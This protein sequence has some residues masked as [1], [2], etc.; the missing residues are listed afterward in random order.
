MANDKNSNIFDSPGLNE[1]VRQRVEDSGAPHALS[2][3]M[4]TF[5]LEDSNNLRIEQSD[6]ETLIRGKTN[7]SIR[8]GRDRPSNIASGYGGMG[9]T[10]AAAIDIVVGAA[11]SANFDSYDDKIV[12]PNFFNDAAR[13]YISQKADLDK[14]FGLAESGIPS[15]FSPARSGIGLKADKI[16]IIGREGIRLVTGKAI[17]VSGT[18]IG[19]ERN[20]GGG[21]IAGVKGI[22][23]IAGN[24][25]DDEIGIDLTSG[26]WKI[27]RVQPIPKGLNTAEAITALTDYVGK[28]AQTLQD[29]MA[30]QQ[31]FNNRTSTHF[32]I[33]T[34]PGAPTLPDPVLIGSNSTLRTKKILLSIGMRT[35]TLALEMYKI[36]YLTPEGK[37]WICS[38]F[39]KTN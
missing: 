32:H 21:R 16:R 4:G 20:A 35:T 13:I 28:I 24:V 39:N 1:G 34:A 9:T 10:D 33:A 17:G 37:F 11:S 25:T 3:M 30:A 15:D 38:R 2:G 31:K 5:K 18:G 29:F 22:E 7:A 36:N 8:F 14:Y 27:K 12:S 26:P 6:A 23:L 19:G